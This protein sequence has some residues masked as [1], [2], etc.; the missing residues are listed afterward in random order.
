MVAEVPVLAVVVATR[1]GTRLEPALASVTWARE[2]AVL[3]PAGEVTPA[4]LPP[5]VRLGGDGV[6]LEALGSAAWL[7]LLGE[8]EVATAAMA[9]AVA[10]AAGGEPAA[11]CIPVEVETL[12]ARLTARIHPVRLAPR[13][14]SHLALDRTLELELSSPAPRRR[15][16]AVLHS[17]VGESVAAA[18]DALVPESRALATLL[19]QAGRTPRALAVAGDPLVAFLRTLGAHAPEPAGLARWVAAVFAGY[20]VALT[21]AMLWEWQHARPAPV[22]VVA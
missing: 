11:W 12:G 8:H 9:S 10:A 19:A 14:G 18:V 13:V 5:D 16:D 3:D 22:R 4:R 15:L 2:R 17:K 20:R 1:G 21:H 6:A 7:L